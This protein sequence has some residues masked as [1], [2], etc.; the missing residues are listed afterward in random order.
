[1][2]AINSIGGCTRFGDKAAI[3]L[4]ERIRMLCTLLAE[5]KRKMQLMSWAVTEFQDFRDC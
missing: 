1:M 2:K 5:I 3:M 4:V